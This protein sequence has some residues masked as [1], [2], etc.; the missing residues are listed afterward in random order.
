[1]PRPGAEPATN[2]SSPLAKLLLGC[3]C[4]GL[5]VVVAVGV[6]GWFLLRH[7]MV[8]DAAEVAALLQE[9]LPGAELPP[10]YTATSGIKLFSFALVAASD[11]RERSIVVVNADDDPRDQLETTVSAGGERDGEREELE[12]AVVAA[13]GHERPARRSREVRDGRPHLQYEIE[14]PGREVRV[15]F[16]GPEDDFDHEGMTAFLASVLRG[17]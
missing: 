4:A 10:G 9:K 8:H 14:I 13:G 2:A 11:A 5:A 3:G 17:R 16:D 15:V 12:P 7:A 1:M 6:G